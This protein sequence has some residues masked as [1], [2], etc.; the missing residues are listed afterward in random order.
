A[1]SRERE[2]NAAFRQSDYT[3]AL[4]LF[5]EA[6]SGYET[7][8]QEATQQAER[9]IQ[10]EPV[11]ASLDHAYA[12]AAAERTRALGADAHKLAADIFNEA[13]ATQVKADGLRGHDLVAAA[14]AYQDAADRYGDA[15]LRA[16]ASRRAK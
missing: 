6:Q 8:A 5:A 11:R 2:G 14:R 4:R 1:Q 7:S 9:D 10:L 16:Q 13:Q 12:A 15:T 3:G